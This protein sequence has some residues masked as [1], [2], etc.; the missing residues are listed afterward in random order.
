MDRKE[1]KLNA[2]KSLVG[3]YFETF[4][5]F[6]FLAIVI[7]ILSCIASILD[8]ALGTT[9]VIGTK[10][11]FGQIVEEKCSLFQSIISIVC[12]CAIGFGL[13]SYFLKISRNED[14][15]FKESYA[16]LDM[17]LFYF[18]LSF[19]VGI[20]VFLWSILFIIPGIIAAISYS[21]VYNIKLDNPEMSVMECIAKSKEIMNGHK[22]D[23]FILELSFIGWIILVPFTL[24]LLT[25]WLVPYMNV[26][27][28]NFYNKLVNK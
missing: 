18:C 4:K 28:C 23:F 3:K 10:E 25:I 27:I 2:K 8:N 12:T 16:K 9:W 17:G 20:F 15:T 22:M 11:Y 26:T 13:S 1:L 14:V 24:G 6:L 7:A 21:F 5:M 19:V